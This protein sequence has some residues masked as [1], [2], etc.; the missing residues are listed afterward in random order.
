MEIKN[1]DTAANRFYSTLDIKG[2]PLISW[3]LFSTTFDTICKTNNDIFQL[4]NLA[5]IN[6]WSHDEDFNEALFKKEQV[7]VVTD[8]ELTIVHATQNIK[9]M[10]GYMP[11]EIL[12]KKPNMFQGVDTCKKTTKIIS[13]AVKNKQPFEAVILNYRK[14]GSSYKCWIKGEPIFNKL[15]DVVNFIAY[16]KEVA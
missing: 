8:A 2:L 12:G 6:K 1:Y 4:Q 16:E 9:K 7:L 5:K 10:N 13:L 14:D 15:G 3:D 11:E